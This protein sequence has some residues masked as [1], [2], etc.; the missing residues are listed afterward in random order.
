MPVRDTAV[1]DLAAAQDVSL[2]LLELSFQNRLRVIGRRIDQ[3]RLHSITLIE[4]PD[5]FILR[6]GRSDEPW[7]FL[8]DFSNRALAD[9]LRDSIYARGE[10]TTPRVSRDL[11]PTGYEDLMRT[12]G[13]E[14]DQRVAEGIVI[15]ELPSLFAV[16]GF[17]PVIGVGEATFRPFSE[18]IGPLEADAMLWRALA[19][20]GTYQHIQSYI[21]PN[22][23]G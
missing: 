18:A 5:G 14:L 13:Y 12:L 2:D 15:T 17:E 23:R 22:F 1:S 3:H 21:P 8:F 19:R 7:P 16:S 20:R 6:A 11:V 10:G 4:I 9:M